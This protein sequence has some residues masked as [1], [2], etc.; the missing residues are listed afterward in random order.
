MILH[1]ADLGNTVRPFYISKKVCSYIAE[2][3]RLQ[4][5]KEEDLGLPITPFMV[6]PDELAVARCE[7]GFLINVAKP[8]FRPQFLFCSILNRLNCKLE[9]NINSWM[10]YS[11]ILELQESVKDNNTSD[12]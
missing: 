4:S 5:K 11:K 10:E 2:E 1:N 7:L 3:F 6:L 12:E 9:D 8:Y